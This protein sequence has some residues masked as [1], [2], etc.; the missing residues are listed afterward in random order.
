[1]AFRKESCGHPS[2][3]QRTPGQ[4]LTQWISERTTELTSLKESPAARY[5]YCTR[6]TA[7]EVQY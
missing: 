1:M 3:T 6:V 4:C 7:A 2:C 5:A